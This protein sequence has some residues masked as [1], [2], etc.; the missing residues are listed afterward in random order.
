MINQQI[1]LLMF[2]WEFPPFNSGGLGTACFG[3]SRALL[4]QDVNLTFVL[5]RQIDVSHDDLKFVFADSKTVNI[6]TVD[7]ILKP[8]L[9]SSTYRDQRVQMKNAIY[10]KSLMDEVMRYA[11]QAGEIAK[12]EHHNVI[13]AHDW[14][15][16]EAGVVA[17]KVSGMPLV[18]HVHA[19]E[20]DRSS[21]G[22]VN[23]D[24]YNIERRGMEYSD[25][26]IAVSNFTKNI[27]TREYGIPEGKV[28]VVHNAIDPE[29]YTKYYSEDVI[30]LKRFFGKIVL[31]AG[32]L[33]LQKGPDY[34]MRAARKVLEYLPDISFIIAGSGD[35]EKQV[36]DMAVH[37]G[38]SHKIFFTG[39]LRGAEL[40]KIYQAADLYVMP[41]V[42]EPFGITTLE[43]I[44][45]NTPALVSRQSGVSE[46]LTHALKVDFWDVDEMANKIISVLS[47]SS[48]QS[49]LREHSKGE[50]GKT[51]WHISARKCID[52]YK[53]L[54]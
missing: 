36:V 34:F 19:T 3:L 38:I 46:I 47:Y 39:F 51:G 35:M 27:I 8:Y 9:N 54:V 49:T 33:T 1:K 15:A 13:H 30:R 16:F 5:P 44:I 20:F 26:I 17:K 22:N 40:Q 18:T 10:G 45:N 7:T 41:S 53:L 43:S 14:L 4:K 24:I 37:Y 42:S 23:Q 29:D 48:L 2:G 25:K 50:V 32:R 11:T 21:N 6:R 28:V 12:E 52:I 31:F